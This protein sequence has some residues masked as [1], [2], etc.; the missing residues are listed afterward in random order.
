LKFLPKYIDH[1]SPSIP[2]EGRER[3][4]T[5]LGL[6]NRSHW[7]LHQHHDK[8]AEIEGIPE[9]NLG[10]IIGKYQKRWEIEWKLPRNDDFELGKP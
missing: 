7:Q 10:K 4:L 6:P 8:T 9:V 1:I 5:S 3:L 2:G